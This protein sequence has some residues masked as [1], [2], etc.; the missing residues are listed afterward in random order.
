[1]R[2]ERQ[3][4]ALPAVRTEMAEMKAKDRLRS[5]GEQGKGRN[6]KYREKQGHTE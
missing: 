2:K 6:L 4:W 3:I 1:M 5:D